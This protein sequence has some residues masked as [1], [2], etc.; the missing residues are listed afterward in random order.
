[1]KAIIL[2]D[3]LARPED[4]AITMSHL[5]NSRIPVRLLDVAYATQ[6]DFMDVNWVILDCWMPDNVLPLS[7]QSLLTRI[8]RETL[9][10][11]NIIE[12]PDFERTLWFYREGRQ[13]VVG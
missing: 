2:H 12:L 3:A 7:V 13:Q 11:L 1:M 5:I 10:Q 8:P 6:Q 4:L 9:M